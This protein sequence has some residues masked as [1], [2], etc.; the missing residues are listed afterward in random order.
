MW[1]CVCVRLCHDNPLLRRLDT[2]TVTEKVVAALVGVNLAVF[3]CWKLARFS[4][5]L[6]YFMQR[7]FVHDIS[8]GKPRTMVSERE[9]P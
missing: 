9:V 1:S 7:N 5:R 6:L 3:G 2:V 4:P 8:F